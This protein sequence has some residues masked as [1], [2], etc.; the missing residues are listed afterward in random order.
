MPEA[1]AVD[2]VDGCGVEA[3]AVL[4]W[5]TLV[6]EDC[7]VLPLEDEPQPASRSRTAVNPL[8]WQPRPHAPRARIGAVDRVIASSFQWINVRRIIAGLLHA[9]IRTSYCPLYAMH[10]RPSVYDTDALARRSR[11]HWNTP[12][13]G[14]TSDTLGLTGVSNMRL[15]PTMALKEDDANH[16]HDSTRPPLGGTHRPRISWRPSRQRRPTG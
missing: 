13:L 10:R 3:G 12:S 8:S 1:A 2:G 4:C 9:G 6:A 15:Y 5:V 11:D 7:V 16:V 14:A